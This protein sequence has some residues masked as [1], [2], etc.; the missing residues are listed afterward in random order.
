VAAPATA[1]EPNGSKSTQS[2]D[3]SKC[4]DNDQ[5]H[6]YEDCN[7]YLQRQHISPTFIVPRLYRTTI[8]QQQTRAH[9]VSDHVHSANFQADAH[10]YGSTPVIDLPGGLGLAIR[11]AC[12]VRWFVRAVGLGLWHSPQ[13]GENVWF[14]LIV[15][16]GI[17]SR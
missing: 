14:F 16:R 10:R 2:P 13:L 17:V 5:K 11:E 3:V 7:K 6:N 9:P 8:T 15:L 4:R 12:A 1:D